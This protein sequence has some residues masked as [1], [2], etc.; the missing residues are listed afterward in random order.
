MEGM[1]YDNLNQM[2]GIFPNIKLIKT[3]GFQFDKKDLQNY[4][5]E[6]QKNGYVLIR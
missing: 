5:E 1:L 3:D 6:L 2:S 4:K